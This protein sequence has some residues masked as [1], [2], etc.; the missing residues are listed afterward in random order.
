M[1][2]PSFTYSS[3]SRFKTCPKQYE[4]HQV[5]KYV[6]FVGTTATIY[7][8]DLHEAAENYI[9][10]GDELPGRFSFVKN[11]LDILKNIP[12]EKLC[13][14][15]MGIA[16]TEDGYTYC[17]Y[18]SPLRYWRGIADLV[19][20]N[21]EEE[22]AWVIDYKTGKSAK[23]A[24]TTQLALIAAAIFLEFPHIKTVKGM[25][26]FVVSNETVKDE[27]EYSN[28]FEVFSNLS[29]LLAR[30]AVAYETNVFNATPNGLC[31]KWCQATRCIHNGNYKE[32]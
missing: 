20:I 30:R 32:A 9:G 10:K 29:L 11:Y 21:N 4:A 6:P 28:R 19:I 25:L 7:G 3:I 5:L 8:T 22:K 17:D 23:Y 31:R 24:D 27:Y 2:I 13:E 14:Y 12:G 15:K 18:E 1:Q 16:K 26:L